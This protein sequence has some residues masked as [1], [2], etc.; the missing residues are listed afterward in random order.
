[1]ISRRVGVLTIL[2]ALLALP[3]PALA[4]DNGLARTPPM[5]W[6]TWRHFGC[7]VSEALI[8]ETAD[9]MVSAGL[10]DAGYAYLV[11]DDCWQGARAADG[12]I[13]ADPARFPSGMKALADYVHARGLKFGLYTDVGDATCQGRPGMLGHELQDAHTYA[14][15]GVDFLKVDW[16]HSAGLEAPKAYAR[17]R[18]ALAAAGRPILLSICEWG[19]SDPAR[20]APDVGNMWRTTGDL[21]AAFDRQP[22]HPS[23]RAQNVATSVPIEMDLGVLQ[24]LDRQAG[25]ARFAAPGGWNDPDMLEAGD[26]RMTQDEQ[27]AQFAL[28]A[29]L[30]APLIAGYDL[31]RVSAQTLAILTDAEVIAIDQDPA[32]RAGDRIARFGDIDIWARPLADGGVAVVLLNRGL[33]PLAVSVDAPLLKLSGPAYCARDVSNHSDL[34]ALGVRL[35]AIVQ[36]HAVQ[37]LRLRPAAGSC[38]G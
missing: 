14:A 20:W 13:R 35:S 9:A 28:W 15:W 16:C 2:A 22:L 36:P 24:A 27:R 10:R 23:A 31:R 30:A 17:I 6:N 8:R 1:V 19:L 29:V 5:G 32:G 26:G 4:L 18:D 11:I 7:H 34:G 25:L 21:A 38:P 3:P 37:L 12:E 33:S